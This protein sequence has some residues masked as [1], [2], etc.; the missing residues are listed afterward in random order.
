MHATLFDSRLKT[1][2]SHKSCPSQFHFFF[3]D[4]LDGF[5]PAPF[6]LSYSVFDFIF[7]IFS[8]MDRALDYAGH[9]VSF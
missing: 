3:P 5:L 8:F 7:P 9:L 1:Y 2:L 4:F 6:L